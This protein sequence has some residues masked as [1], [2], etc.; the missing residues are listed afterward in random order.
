MKKV[1]LCK[2][3]VGYALQKTYFGTLEM[4]RSIKNRLLLNFVDLL[5]I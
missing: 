2:Y 1:R 3:Q 5:S 4:K